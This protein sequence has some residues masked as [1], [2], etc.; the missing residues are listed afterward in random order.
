MHQ[1]SHVGLHVKSERAVP[2]SQNAAAAAAAVRFLMR[3]DS[4]EIPDKQ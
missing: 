2:T 1:V 4:L 3:T